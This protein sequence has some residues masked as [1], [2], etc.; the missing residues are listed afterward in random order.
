[1]DN[2]V[3]WVEV[4][5]PRAVGGGEGAAFE[6]V[7]DMDSELGVAGYVVDGG[8]CDP[9]GSGVDEKRSKILYLR[10][11]VPSVLTARSLRRRNMGKRLGRHDVTT[12]REHEDDAFFAGYLNEDRLNK[13]RTNQ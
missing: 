1:M 5:D 6:S 10:V 7:G 9:R 2:V 13:G 8:D 4:T 11:K 12:Y 3:D